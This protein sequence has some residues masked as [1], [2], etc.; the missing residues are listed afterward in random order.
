V[1]GAA[2]LL[3]A[4][5][6][7]GCA[8]A[9]PGDPA[10][11]TIQ[12]TEPGLERWHAVVVERGH[13]H[14]D[15]SE[16]PCP[17]PGILALTEGARTRA[18]EDFTRAIGATLAPL[19]CRQ[20]GPVYG[21]ADRLVLG[22]YRFA[23]DARTPLEAIMLDFPRLRSDEPERLLKAG[24]FTAAW[25][26]PP[27]TVEQVLRGGWTRVIR[28]PT[29]YEFELFIVLSRPDGTGDPTR[30]IARVEAGTR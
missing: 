6:P 28:R 3:L 25:E 19:C 17:M 4:L 27:R 14:A 15:L 24:A 11:L 16:P 29:G 20:D 1:R 26:R 22:L 21:G 7:A 23:E 2:A 12:G 13:L 30:V 8:A 5:L 10:L 18:A 9:P